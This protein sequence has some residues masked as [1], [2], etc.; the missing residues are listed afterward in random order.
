MNAVKSFKEHK[1]HICLTKASYL[2]MLKRAIFS[3]LLPFT[4]PFLVSGAVALFPLKPHCNMMACSF[5]P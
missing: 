1:Y 5:I 4:F 2:V 3:G